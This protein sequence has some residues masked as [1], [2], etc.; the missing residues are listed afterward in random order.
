MHW[1]AIRPRSG[2]TSRSW[3]LLCAL[4]LV[5]EAA[6][7]LLAVMLPRLLGL[8]V[9]SWLMP[10]TAYL[11]LS[12]AGL[13]HRLLAARPGRKAAVSRPTEPARPARLRD[14]SKEA[15]RGRRTGETRLLNPWS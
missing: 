13:R 2:Q 12:D 3:R 14:I 9:V 8:A 1:P 6:E 10:Y 7:L 5:I 11:A 4:L 15:A